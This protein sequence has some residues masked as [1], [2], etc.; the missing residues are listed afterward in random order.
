MILQENYT[1]NNG[2]AIPRLGLGTWM[3]D[4]D[5]A[6]DAVLAAVDAGYRHFDTAQAYGNE[7]DV[8]AGLR[9]CGLPRD[10]L[11]VTTK[12]D[13]GIKDFAAAR[14]AI[15]GSLVALGLDEIDLMIIHSPQPWDRFRN[16]ER[17]AEGNLQAW[18]ALEEACAA[19]KIR[20]IGLS[21]FE[22][23]DIHNILANGSMRPAVNQILAHVG[24]MPFEL[25]GYCRERDI[26]VEAYSPIGHGEILHNAEIAAIASNYGVGAAQLAIRFC[27]E[28]GLLPLPK[29]ANPA[30]MRTNADLDFTISDADMDALKAVKPVRDYGESNMFPVFGIHARA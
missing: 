18:R 6:A 2:V 29:T 21:N 11:F 14:D 24:N 13:A 23:A 9:D 25:I 1:L 12:L 19:G 16:G 8:G 10:A 7:R 26:L 4:D 3:I 15:D 30:H 28:L 20:A 27:L 5:K 17:F 22:Q